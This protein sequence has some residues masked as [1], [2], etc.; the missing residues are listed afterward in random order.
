MMLAVLGH[1]SWFSG[2]YQHGGK[3]L[4]LLESFTKQDYFS[5]AISYKTVNNTVV[6]LKA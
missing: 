2:R 5:V 6:T 3:D 1:A 4:E